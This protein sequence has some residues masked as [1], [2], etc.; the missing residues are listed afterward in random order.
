MPSGD[1]IPSGDPSGDGPIPP[2]CAEAEPL[3]TKTAVNVASDQRVKPKRACHLQ[4]P[5]SAVGIARTA[6]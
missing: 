6:P 3:A 4:S 1:V 2:I 5:F